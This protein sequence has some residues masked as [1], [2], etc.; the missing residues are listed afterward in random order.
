[1]A[2]V[3]ED[4]EVVRGWVRL[5]V[6]MMVTVVRAKVRFRVRMMVVDAVLQDVEG[7][8]EHDLRYDEVGVVVEQV[9]A[10]AHVELHCAL[11]TQGVIGAGLRHDAADTPGMILP[12][13]PGMW[14]PSAS[15]FSEG[16]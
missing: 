1:M 15:L 2:A 6:R 16:E 4:V 3:L 11:H 5:C 10:H 14:R 13:S 7:L 9:P 12:R 8:G